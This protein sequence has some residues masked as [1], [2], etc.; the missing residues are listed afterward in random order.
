MRTVT[1]AQAKGFTLVELVM[2]IVLLSALGVM[3][4]SFIG[5]GVDIYTD[6]AER[7]KSLNSV[8]FV[9]ERLRREA[10]N[11]L[12]NSAV[13]SAGDQCLTFTPIIASTIYGSDFPIAPISASSATISPLSTNISGASA[14]VYLLSPNELLG[15]KV[16]PIKNYSAG[17]ATLSFTNPASFPLSSPAKRVYITQ[18][19]I[20]Y[21]FS[22]DRIFRSVQ[23]PSVPQC[24]NGVLMA[25]NIT[26]SF[27]VSNAS[28]QR[29]GLV[30]VT[31]NLDFDG[32]VPV[33]QA[34][35]IN[36]VP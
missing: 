30:Q 23:I 19:N 14:T 32:P 34:I 35:H 15:N 10:A 2:V 28:L 18:N 5:T 21:Y 20:S 16:W 11:A 31:Y 4:S 22:G 25:K 17:Q 29:N 26:G 24:S 1:S 9:M 7:D 33:E 27:K 6:I 3:T 8:R 13:V 12:P 36:N